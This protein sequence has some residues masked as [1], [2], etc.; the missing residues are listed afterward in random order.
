MKYNIRIEVENVI[1]LI[2]YK[3]SGGNYMSVSL[4]SI[5]IVCPSQKGALH[6]ERNDFDVETRFSRCVNTFLGEV[7]TLY[8][9]D[10]LQ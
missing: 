1:I 6:M 7:I 3:V 9:D 5:C 8:N 2:F 4:I 10:K